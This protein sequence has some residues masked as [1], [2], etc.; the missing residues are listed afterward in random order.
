[1]YAQNCQLLKDLGKE[2]S[3]AKHFAAFE[4][5]LLVFTPNELYT[6]FD[7]ALTLYL[8]SEQIKG[9]GEAKLNE[10]VQYSQIFA[11]FLITLIG[12]GTIGVDVNLNDDYKN[13]KL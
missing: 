11:F 12:Q 8:R 1:M 5:S 2:E 9:K 10:V 13:K 6:I 7:R 3:L 4:R